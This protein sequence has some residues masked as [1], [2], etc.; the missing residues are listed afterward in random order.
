M[1]YCFNLNLVRK[2]KGFVIREYLYYVCKGED[3]WNLFN[4]VKL[5]YLIL[6]D[7]LNKFLKRF[8]INLC[9]KL[10]IN[11]IKNGEYRKVYNR[12]RRRVKLYNV[13]EFLKFKN[14]RYR[15]KVI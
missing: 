13:Y 14:E 5:I 15:K 7:L 1:N 8:K 11:F 4:N 6:W 3:F 9:Y 12:L 2:L 10:E